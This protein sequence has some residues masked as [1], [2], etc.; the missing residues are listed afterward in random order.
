MAEARGQLTDKPR[1]GKMGKQ[2]Q[3]QPRGEQ[4]NNKRKRKRGN[5]GG[6]LRLPDPV[7][8]LFDRLVAD[9]KR[10]RADKILQ[11]LRFLV[12]TEFLTQPLTHNTASSE[13]TEAAPAAVETA[14]GGK[15]RQQDPTVSSAALQ[16]L[17]D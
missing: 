17:T 16:T 14:E 3:R 10:A 12:K 11:C 9:Q 7:P 2:P 4:R 6:K 8:D 5:N 1:Q 15:E 13:Q